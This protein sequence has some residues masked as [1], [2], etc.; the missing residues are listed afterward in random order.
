MILVTVAEN[1]RYFMKTIGL[2]FKSNDS[3]TA[4]M[5]MKNIENIRKFLPE[6]HKEKTIIRLDYVEEL[7]IVGG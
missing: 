3:L 4:S 2:H 1:D 7:V 5:D 6:R